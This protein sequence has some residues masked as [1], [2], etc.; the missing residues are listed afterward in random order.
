MINKE[1]IDICEKINQ[2]FNANFS[3]KTAVLMC[4]GLYEENSAFRIYTDDAV[5]IESLPGVFGRLLTRDYQAYRHVHD[6]Q[7]LSRIRDC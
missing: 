7:S 5:N 2:V 1:I 4:P 3:I 6:V